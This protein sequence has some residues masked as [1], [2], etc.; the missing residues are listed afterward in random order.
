MNSVLRLAASYPSTFYIARELPRR[1]GEAMDH[2]DF[3]IGEFRNMKMP[4]N[5]ALRRRG[6]PEG[7]V[8]EAEILEP[9]DIASEG[10]ALGLLVE[11][12]PPQPPR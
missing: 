3:V 2:L 7:I 10:S 12:G 11:T 4:P 6:Y 1:A 5:W 9:P 8:A